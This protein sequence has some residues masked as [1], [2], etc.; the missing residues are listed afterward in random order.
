MPQKDYGYPGGTVVASKVFSVILFPPEG[1]K[2]GSLAHTASR[3]IVRFI[4]NWQC[5]SWTATAPITTSSNKGCCA[6][7]RTITALSAY[8]FTQA[9]SSVTLMRITQHI[10]SLCAKLETHNRRSRLEFQRQL[11]LLILFIKFIFVDMLS[12]KPSI[13]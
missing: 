6:S 8:I 11:I 10:G 12:S 9:R 5:V 7:D 4:F 1:S 3:A 13:I 2:R